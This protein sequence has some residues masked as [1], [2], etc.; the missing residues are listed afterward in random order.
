MKV[1]EIILNNLYKMTQMQESFGMNMVALVDDQP[2]LLNLKQFL[3]AFLRHRREVVTRRNVFELRKARDRGHVLEGLAVALSNVDEIVELI[4]SAQTPA[5]AKI[6]LMSRVWRSKLVEE[7][8]ARASGDQ[9]E[10]F[11]P[12][13]LSKEFGLGNS[14]YRLSETQTQRILEMQLQRL[15]G[16]EQDKIVAEYKEVMDKI[17][18]LLD[19]LSKPERVTSIIVAELKEIKSQFGD[20]RR[21]EI[22]VSG[23]EMSIEDLIANEDVVVTMSHTGY[24]KYQPV[25]DYR[26]QKR[27]GRGKQAT[28]TK[29]DDFIENL[30]IA[31]THDYVLCFSN[32][33]RVHWLKVYEIPQGSRGSR[34]SQLSIVAVAAE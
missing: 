11:R 31:K 32:K 8:L 1:P 5:E 28:A 23:Q 27:G 33:G 18:D 3:E 30:F 4:K 2:R 25:A 21:S 17:A 7:M 12:E 24:I 10:A 26:A 34:G 14:G 13:N 20:K 19:I 16:L 22:V 15:T 6:K 29:E 9:A